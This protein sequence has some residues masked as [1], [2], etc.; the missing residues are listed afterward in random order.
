M[1]LSAPLNSLV[2]TLDAAVLEVLAATESS[3][4]VSQIQRLAS[5]GARSGINRVLT[6]LVEHGL[7]LAE[8]TNLGHVYRLNRGHLLADSVL[9]AAGARREFVRRLTQACEELRPQV[10]SAALFG[11]AARGD[12]GP[13]SDVD[14]LLVVDDEAQTDAWDDQLRDLEDRVLRWTGNRLECV[15]FTRSHLSVVVESGEPLVASLRNEAIPLTGQ[16]LHTLLDT[17]VDR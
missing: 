8:P 17:K 13:D 2:P 10:I 3:L 9:S 16:P 11:S 15:V 7:V 6:R 1:D 5:R 14:L 12:A 4:G